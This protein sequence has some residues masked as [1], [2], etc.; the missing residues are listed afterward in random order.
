MKRTK[1]RIGIFGGAFNPVHRGH[2][3]ISRSFLA[4]RLIH[5]L[6]IMPTPDPPHKESGNLI[7]LTHRS[8]MLR[9]AFQNEKHVRITDLERDLPAPSYTWQTLTALEESYA[10]HHFYLCIGEDSLVT[11]TSWYRWREILAM[12]PLLVAERSGYDRTVCENE[13][14][15]RAIFA[16]HQPVDISSTEIRERVNSSYAKEGLPPAVHEYITTRRLYI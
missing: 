9:R 12:T 15:E 11:F 10:D 13:V 6:W 1:R 16:E 7:S 3:A 2:I 8:E 5:E 4:S 14:L